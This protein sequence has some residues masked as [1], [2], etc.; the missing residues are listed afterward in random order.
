LTAKKGRLG[1]KIHCQVCVPSSPFESRSF[2]GYSNKPRGCQPPSSV[3]LSLFS[4]SLRVSQA[5]IW[6]RPVQSLWSGS[7][8]VS[9]TS[10]DVK[11]TSQDTKPDQVSAPPW[12]KDNPNLRHKWRYQN[13]DEYRQRIK[14]SLATYRRSPLGREQYKAANRKYKQR[15]EIRQRRAEAN[16]RLQR[17]SLAYRRA[18]ALASSMQT[19]K[20]IKEAWTWKLHA[21]L[22]A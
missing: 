13:D 10:Q 1:N 4:L 2:L 12:T 5:N 9:S 6:T 3:M 15:P 16:A 21:R 22:D 8:T 19:G 14:D 11:S 18:L 7:R 20:W 17:E